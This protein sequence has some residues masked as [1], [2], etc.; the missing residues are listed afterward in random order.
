MVEV[1]VIME[2]PTRGVCHLAVLMRASRYDFVIRQLLKK[3]EP[4]RIG[5][6]Q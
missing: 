1:F 6:R 4:F 5:F 2:S 3:C